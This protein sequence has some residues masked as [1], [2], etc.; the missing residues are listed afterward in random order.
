MGSP[1]G[2]NSKPLLD[3]GN[4][5]P[6][7]KRVTDE[8]ANVLESIP[9]PPKKADNPVMSTRKKFL[10]CQIWNNLVG[11]PLEILP[12]TKLPQNKVILQRYLSLRSQY[13]TDKVSSLVSIL[14]TEVTDIWRLARIH[15]LEEKKCKSIIKNLI[16]KYSNFKHYKPKKNYQRKSQTGQKSSTSCVT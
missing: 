13:P 5:I 3:E 9:P 14:Y 1:K 11:S 4:I 15:T 10:D 16:Q 2:S 6:E 8:N 7:K 12:Q